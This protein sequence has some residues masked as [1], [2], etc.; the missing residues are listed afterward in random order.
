[1]TKKSSDN[2][3]TSDNFTLTVKKTSIVYTTLYR[4]IP[5]VNKAAQTSESLQEIEP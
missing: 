5:H 2:D 4:I 1:M 3:V